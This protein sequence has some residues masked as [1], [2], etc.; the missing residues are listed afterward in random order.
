[1]GRLLILL[2]AIF[3]GLPVLA[4]AILRFAPPPVTAF[5]LQ[6]PVK[7]VQ[8]AWVP[9]GGIAEVAGKAIVAAEDQKFWS[10]DG[11][12]LE[13]IED[14][15]RDNQRRKKQRGASTI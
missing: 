2:F 14:A 4:I 3:V 7:P 15:Y 13:A 8:Y 1:M 9:A 6:S 11:F 5:M 12:D 10:H